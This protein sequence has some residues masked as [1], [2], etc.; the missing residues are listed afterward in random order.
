MGVPGPSF[1]GFLK[2]RANRRE[3]WLMIGVLLAASFTA[4][5]VAPAVQTAGTVAVTFAQIRRLHDLGRTGWWVVAILGLQVVAVFALF[6]A[7]LPEDSILT[8]GN[9]ISVL[10]PIVILGA[11]PGQ[12]FE[13]RFGPAPGQ[14]PLKEIF[15]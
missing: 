3:Y 14:R 2:G 8:I 9:L 12:P 7:S 10:P 11:I 6:A 4:A 1:G 13:N 15:S 5:Y